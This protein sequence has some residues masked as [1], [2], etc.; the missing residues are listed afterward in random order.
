MSEQRFS[1]ALEKKEIAAL[2][3]QE[4][5]R[6]LPVEVDEI[7]VLS[8]PGMKYLGITIDTT[9]IYFEFIRNTADN[10]VVRI[11]TICRLMANV[12]CPLPCRRRFLISAV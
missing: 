4:V 7:M 3:K 2:T 11:L 1:L 5:P 12:G 10:A 6:V 8:K 9:V